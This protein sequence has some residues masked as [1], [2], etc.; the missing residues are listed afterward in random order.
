MPVQSSLSRP[1]RLLAS[2]LM[3]GL[4]LS[5]ASCGQADEKTAEQQKAEQG[6]PAMQ[7]SKMPN[8]LLTETDK[9]ITLAAAQP[10]TSPTRPATE[11]AAAHSSSELPAIPNFASY[12]DVKQ[13]KK[14]FFDFML[15]LVKRVDEDVLKERHLVEKWNPAD[16]MSNDMLAL[17]EK[18]RV[19]EN[20]DA[21]ATKAELLKRVQVIPPSLVLAQGANESAWGTS[22]F[23]RTGNNYFGQWCFVKGCGLVPQQRNDGAIHE[24]AKFDHPLESVRS[25]VLNLNRHYTYEKLRTLRQ[26]EI[27]KQGYPTGINLAAGLE[28]YS[29]R[30][31]E[32]VKE[33]RSMISYNKLDKLDPQLLSLK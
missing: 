23:A 20:L 4:L 9:P 26:Q 19:D 14:V 13:K 22:R 15:D 21:K 2:T 16:G 7:V 33:I 28:N 12:T 31:M 17:V 3:G 27:A 32:Y 8:P 24:V 6:Q 11:K 10:T 30:R 29:E 1:T 18:Y 5:V 25:Y